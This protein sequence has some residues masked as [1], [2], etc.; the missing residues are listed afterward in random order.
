MT[1]EFHPEARIEYFEAIAYYE[2]RQHGLGARF[3]IEIEN[4][5][6]RVLESPLRW[7]Q[8]ERDVRR[9]LAHKFPYGILYAVEEG[10]IFILAIMH[11]SREPNYWRERS[12]R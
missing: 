6:Q 3:T 9:C 8:V 5:V 7:Q 1:Y 4:T 2:E 11:H 12:K 10:R